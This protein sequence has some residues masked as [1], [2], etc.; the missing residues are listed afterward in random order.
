MRSAPGN[1]EGLVPTDKQLPRQ[2]IAIP[3][4]V[5]GSRKNDRPAPGFLQSGQEHLASMQA[6]IFHQNNARE[7]EFLCANPI[8]LTALGATQD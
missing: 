1:Q 7:S 4:I 2:G 8:H 6:Y 5:A 3:A